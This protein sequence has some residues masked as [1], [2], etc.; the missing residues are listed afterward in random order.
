M[1]APRVLPELVR[2]KNIC[3]RP[4]ENHTKQNETKKEIKAIKPVAWDIL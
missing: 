3:G 1:F 2:I 4:E